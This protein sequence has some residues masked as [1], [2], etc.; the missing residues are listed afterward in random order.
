MHKMKKALVD[1]FG[2]MALW[3]LTISPSKGAVRLGQENLV[4]LKG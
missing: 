4:Y 2:K 1:V 3:K